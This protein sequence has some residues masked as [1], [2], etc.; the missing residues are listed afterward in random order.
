VVNFEDDGAFWLPN[1][2]NDELVGRIKYDP[3]EGAELTVFG[4]FPP[5][6][7]IPSTVSHSR[8]HGVA[9][10]R[11]FTL[12]GCWSKNYTLQGPGIDVEKFI[13]RRAFSG[14]HFA[15]DMPLEFDRVAAS[16]DQLA[17][18]VRRSTPEIRVDSP[19]QDNW[20]DARSVG[21]T[22]PIPPTETVALDSLELSLSTTWKTKSDSVSQA[23]VH[24][25]PYFEIQ[26]K[27]PMAL[28]HILMDV[29]GIQDLITLSIDAPCVPTGIDLWRP[30]ITRQTSNGDS[31]PQKIGL[32]V[33]NLAEHVRLSDHQ[34]R[35]RFLFP[36]GAIGGLPTVGNW[37]AVS[38]QY[39]LVVG[40]LLTL[41]YSKR[42]YDENKFS[43]ALMA[44]ESFDRMRFPNEV[45]PR[46]EYRSYRRKIVK[47]IRK[48]IG[49]NTGDWLN[50]QLI[51]S[52][53]PRLRQR[54]TRIADY[55]GSGFSEVAGDSATWAAVVTGVR[56]RLTHHDEKQ[57]LDRRTG[58]LLSLAES[59][60]AA[61]MLCLL[62]D[63]GV[64]PAVL[65]Q[66]KDSDE[67]IFLKERLQEII[68]R[69]VN[70]LRMR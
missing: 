29:N 57:P 22:F 8:I 38:R 51:H 36:F 3:A 28:D 63:C 43:N 31:N 58:D 23:S 6:P 60:Y 42:L 24:Q 56:N 68:P 18:W 62:R 49:P 20:V 70:S 50:D 1:L 13:V 37:L 25:E 2:P 48:N 52:N 9:G 39:R 55:A 14:A 34:S 61:V 53:E 16:F 45:T 26:Y 7:G 4:R 67:A 33:A 15:P 19:N 46:T 5:Q 54:L 69:Y 40:A 17:S 12:D 44:A 11:E 30:G 65:D 27:E 41:K 21:I 66:F 47:T 35:G 32:H 59:V 10:G 64:T